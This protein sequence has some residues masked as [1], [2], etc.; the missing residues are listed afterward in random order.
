MSTKD[1]GVTPAVLLQH[2]QG[3]ETRLSERISGV[4]S[5]LSSRLDRVEQGLADLKTT[6]DRNHIQ[7]TAQ[8]DMLDKRL[9][10]IECVQ[11]PTL[12]KAVGIR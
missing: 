2:M 1:D 6:V 8:I 11:V 3:M 9:D 5:T 4:E 12:K 7:T 10:D